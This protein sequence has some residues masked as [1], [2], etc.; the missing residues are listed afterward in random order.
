VG[1]PIDV[2]L[3]GPDV[4]QL[5]EAAARVSEALASLPA[6]YDVSDSFRAGKAEV[7]LSILPAGEALGVTL[8][9]L[10]RQVRQAFYGEEAQRVQ[11]GRDDVR[12]MVRYPESE[13]RSLGDLDN[14]AWPRTRSSASC[15]PTCCPRSWPTTPA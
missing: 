13:R 8:A 7:K 12:V 14:R 1:D 6:V 2:Q 9:D 5:E 15:V 4:E 10:A 3:A 11:R